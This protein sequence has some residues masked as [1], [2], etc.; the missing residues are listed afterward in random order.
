ML[1]FT[2]LDLGPAILALGLVLTI[3]PIVR[4]LALNWGFVAIPR[5]DRWHQ[6]PTAKM[7]GL[8]I[9]L[10]V[11]LTQG[12]CCEVIEHGWILLASSTVLFAVGFIDDF[13]QLKPHQKLIGQMMGAVLVVSVGIIL[14]WTIWPSINVILTIVWLIGITNAVNM[15]DNMDGLASGVAGIAAAFLATNF[16][17]NEHQAE[18]QLLT[19]FAVA[20]LGF[21][22]YN[23]HPASIFMGDCGALFIGFFLAS[24]ALLHVSKVRPNYVALDLTVFVLPF[25]VPIFD[26]SLV[27]VLRLLARRPVTQ[28]GRDHASHR[29][30]ALGMSERH[31][32]LLLYA[33]AIL[34][35]LLSLLIR[36]LSIDICLVGI[37]IMLLMLTL[38]GIQLGRVKVYNDSNVHARLRK[39][40][41]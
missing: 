21:L 31:A 8:A 2:L 23:S 41:C 3:T 20:L 38:L 13:R 35:G 32:V 7:G 27:T 26:T 24:T 10:A 18:A 36:S 17:V 30:V 40:D 34:A 39:P 37:L 5:G 1:A 25:L 9:Y 16:I 29:L 14:P 11:V 22:V 15:L 6:R 12:L 33:L 4:Y 28:G 19:M